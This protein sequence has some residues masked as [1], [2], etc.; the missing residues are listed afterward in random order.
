MNSTKQIPNISENNNKTQRLIVFSTLKWWRCLC[1]C[2]KH[3]CAIAFSDYKKIYCGFTPTKIVLC[4]YYQVFKYLCCSPLVVDVLCKN[5]MWN[6]KFFTSQFTLNCL[7]TFIIGDN[8]TLYRSAERL[9]V[10]VCVFYVC[11]CICIYL[12]IYTQ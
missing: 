2:T 7:K 11:I 12:D 10:R 8:A 1:F 3:W 9:V 5:N 4:F 6:Y